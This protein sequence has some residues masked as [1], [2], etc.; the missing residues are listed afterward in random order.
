MTFNYVRIVIQTDDDGCVSYCVEDHEDAFRGIFERQSDAILFAECLDAQLRIAQL[1]GELP[2]P[3]HE[4]PKQE[5]RNE[6][7]AQ[8]WDEQERRMDNG[9]S[10]DSGGKGG[11]DFS[12]HDAPRIRKDGPS[13]A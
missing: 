11:N 6:T 4:A 13:P 7:P 3:P 5:E 1:R 12:G 8:K 10:K 9:M 2:L